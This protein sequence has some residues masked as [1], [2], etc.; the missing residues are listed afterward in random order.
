MYKENSRLC[1][2]FIQL[3]AMSR[4][5]SDVVLRKS[6]N[7]LS[8]IQRRSANMDC[9]I[10]AHKVGLQIS[11][12]LCSEIQNTNRLWRIKTEIGKILRS[13]CERKGIEII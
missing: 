2:E 3:I 8:N 1:M 10:L 6:V 5:S 9:E 7:R 12:S 4:S 13:L 11:Y